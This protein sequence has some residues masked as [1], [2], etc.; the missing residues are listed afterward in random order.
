MNKFKDCCEKH[1]S[2]LNELGFN[3]IYSHKDMSCGFI[4][5]VTA[6]YEKDCYNIEIFYAPAVHELDCIFK[7]GKKN[8][9]LAEALKFCEITRFSRYM[10]GADPEK[11]IV[12]LSNKLKAVF[13]KIDIT[14]CDNFEKIYTFTKVQR[15]EKSKEFAIKYE[16]EKDMK[17]ADGYW[18]NKQYLKARD[19]YIEHYCHLT[20]LQLKRLEY[21]NKKLE[22]S[23]N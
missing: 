17:T 10:V 23:Q 19:L 22:A 15:E 6:V 13:E 8:F 21:I 12:D 3:A 14:R 18:N 16:L 2:F 1:L 4:G 7:S 9:Y 5:G 20:K 11:G